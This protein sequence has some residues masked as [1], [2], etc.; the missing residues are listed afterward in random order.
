LTRVLAHG[1]I[2][3]AARVFDGA[4]EPLKL[5]GPLDLFVMVSDADAD[6]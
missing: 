1:H 3:L 2:L 5:I 6:G 4:S